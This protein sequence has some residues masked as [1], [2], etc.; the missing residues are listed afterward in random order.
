M[1]KKIRLDLSFSKTWAEG[2]RLLCTVELN[3]L[4]GKT[5]VGRLTVSFERAV[6]KKKKTLFVSALMCM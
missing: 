3:P 6:E 5:K 2:N 4:Y 1:H